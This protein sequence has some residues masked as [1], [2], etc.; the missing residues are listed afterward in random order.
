MPKP[1][2]IITLP[3]FPKTEDDIHFIEYK[4]KQSN[5]DLHKDYHVLFGFDGNLKNLQYQMFSDK[6]I[7]PIELDKLKEILNLKLDER[8]KT[9]TTENV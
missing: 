5:P 6:E 8:G 3:F 4:H 1:I 9:D 2:F 7:E